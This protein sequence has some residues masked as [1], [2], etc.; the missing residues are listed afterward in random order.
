VKN[1]GD[2]IILLFLVVILTACYGSTPTPTT[3]PTDVMGTALSIIR[4]EVAVTQTAIP[5]ITP[6]T[7]TITPSFAYSGGHV[8]PP[9]DRLDYAMTTAPKIY[10]LFPYIKEATLYGEYA[11]CRETNDF[12]NLVVYV[13][14]QPIETVNAA[15]LN[16]FQSE[17]WE[18]TEA[19]PSDNVRT[20][21]YSV[22]RIA[23]KDTPAFERLKVVLFDETIPHGK[24]YIRV[25]TELTHIET[26][27]NFNYLSNPYGIEICPGA[28]WFWIRLN[29]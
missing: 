17:K 16:Y 7:P 8:S 27:E 24:D 5:T 23:S 21:T 15:F 14:T 2:V 18:F 19:L 13:V 9:D 10:N 3:S 12:Q 26:K 1:V 6:I 11:G 22:Y 29:K 20:M 25:R 4:T 28:W